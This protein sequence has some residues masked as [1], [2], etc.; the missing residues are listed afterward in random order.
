MLTALLRYDP[1]LLIGIGPLKLSAHG[2]MTAVGVYIGMQVIRPAAQRMNL[3]ME[4]LYSLMTWAVLG[5]LVGARVA[6]LV[7]HLDLYTSDPVGALRLWEGGLSLLGGI[8]GAVLICLPR[9]RREGISFLEI[10]DAIAPG[11]AV[12]ISIGRIGDL[13][14]ADHLGKPTNFFL[15]YQCPPGPTGS[16]CVAPVGQGVH[17][18][19][20]YDLIA[21]AMLFALLMWLRRWLG[22]HPRRVGYLASVFGV[23]YGLARFIEGFFRLDLTHGSGLSGSQWTALGAV[24]GCAIL[25]VTRRRN[26]PEVASGAGAQTVPVGVSEG[27]GELVHL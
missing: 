3:T 19:A 11:L 15:G 22:S 17:H 21:T 5:A 10:A 24:F 20:L 14:I 18:T 7:G 27:L 23:G 6:F 8:T 16:P 25:L 26:A 9:L 13:V 4:W 2:I 12:G 1:L